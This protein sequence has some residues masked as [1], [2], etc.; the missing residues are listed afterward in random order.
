MNLRRTN[1]TPRINLKRPAPSATMQPTICFGQNCLLIRQAP[2]RPSE[3][4]FK[5]SRTACSAEP[6][7]GRGQPAEGTSRGKE[8]G[9]AAR[10]N[11][12]LPV[13]L[14]QIEQLDAAPD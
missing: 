4:G 7:R 1:S 8:S 10:V 13:L 6:E 3:T 5:S 9:R 11:L 12:T 2:R 14:A